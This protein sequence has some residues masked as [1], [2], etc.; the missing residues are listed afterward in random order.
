MHDWWLALVAAAFGQIG[1][2]SEPT[3][4]YRQH[5]YNEVGAKN[6]GSLRY[7]LNRLLSGEQS[8]S[9]LND[10]YIQAESF[11]KIYE[12]KLTSPYLEIVKEYSLIPEYNKIKRFQTISKYDF[13]KIGFFRKC[14]QILFL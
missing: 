14:G 9:V 2:V 1:F 6:A 5:G 11:L 8:K 12:S 10:T 3:I 7:N 13:W 4:L